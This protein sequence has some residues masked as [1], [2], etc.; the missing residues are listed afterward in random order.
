[1]KRN[2][3]LVI[4]LLAATAAP[5]F[6]QEAKLVA[7]LKSSATLEEKSAACRQLARIATKESVPT[8]A[9]LLGDEKLSYMARYVLETIP[10]PSVDA[11]L[12]DALGKVK[13]RPLLGVIGSL[14]VRRDAKAVDAIAK[15]L[16]SS[17]AETVQAAARALG[18]IGTPEAAKALE[19]AL[20]GATGANQLAICEGLLRCAEAL[21]APAQASQS[22]E[23]YDRLFGLSQAPPQVRAAALR[24]AIL[25]RG[26]VKGIPLL[27]DAIRGSDYVLTA[28]AART[29][30]ELPGAEVTA[31][32]AAELLKL[33]A[34]KQVLLINTL[35]YRGDASAGP[36]LLALA[37]KGPDAVR[38]AAVENLTHLGYTPALP[39]L[40]K[41][42][43]AGGGELATAA[44]TCLANFP[45][46][47]A[48]AAIQAMLSNHDAKVRSLAVQMIGQR[49]IAGSTVKLL[50]AAEDD[51]ETVR[52]AAFKALRQQAVIADLPGLLNVLVKVRSSADVQAAEVALLALCSRESRP[53]AKNVVI[54]K[55]E[56]GDL[57]AG[58][59]AKVTRKVAA[60]VKAGV[61]AIEATNDSFGDPADGRVKQLRVEYSVN[62]VKNSLTVHEGETLTFTAISTPP[63]I[64]DAI[65]GALSEARGEP[66]LALLRSLRTAG[67]PKALETIRAA[68]ADSNGQ[69]KDT[70]QHILCD[71]PTADA[72]PLIADLVA[73]AP[74]K[75][76]KILALRGLVRLMPQAEL[77]ASKKFEMLKTAM[78]QTD[79]DEERRL[80]LSGLGN[81]PNDEAFA[82]V[83]FCLDNPVLREEACIAAVAIA[84]KLDRSHDAHIAAVMTHV[85]KA[86]T[87]KDLAGRAN[88]LA[89]RAKD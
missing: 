66:K 61:L 53:A 15:L 19:A 73:T 31:A 4:V 64:V 43:L 65:C 56:Y 84:E 2:L 51:E 60:M 72:V 27:L 11:A 21:K 59:S 42:S 54:I 46:T 47:E 69:V 23:I 62:G 57:P 70:A 17:D 63:A 13:G 79:R 68:L 37:A 30:M 76:I 16:A 38:L 75:T 41:L 48:D 78:G 58:P 85:A 32:L 8:L 45:G 35:G 22:Q 88:A 3:F 12:R 33:P 36:A 1:M 5:S 83:A 6:A 67:G 28:A 71:W 80:V 81:V 34:D 74:T 86:T 24:G 26:H 89:R 44:R 87:S 25:I 20:A 82:L 49:N 18:N 77:P 14:G 55:A 10:D 7:V 39:L 29:S 40:A 52:A 50:Q 9:S